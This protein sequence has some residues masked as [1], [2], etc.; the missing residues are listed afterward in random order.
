MITG[1]TIL[2]G[3]ALARNGAVTLDSNQITNCVA[4]VAIPEPATT[5]LF[6]VGGALL[7]RRL[8]SRKGRIRS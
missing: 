6:L 4:E 5:T 1:A 2:E 7:S 8:P 3:S